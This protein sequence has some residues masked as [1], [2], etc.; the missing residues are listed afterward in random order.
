LSDT[1]GERVINGQRLIQ[2][3]SD[4]FLGWLDGAGGKSFYLRQ[5]RDLKWSPDISQ[6][7]DKEVLGY[8]Q[9]CGGALARAHA[10]SGNAQEISDYL[11]TDDDFDSA[12]NTFALE[13]SQQVHA[14]YAEFIQA[15]DEGELPTDASEDLALTI[16]VDTN[17]AFILSSSKTAGTF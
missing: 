1:P 13:Y 10:R 17:G 6:I 11:G 16:D 14:D 15:I 2:A 3:A 7:K 8:A 9:I 4:A 5:L 12:M